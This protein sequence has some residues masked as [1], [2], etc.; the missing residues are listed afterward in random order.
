[1]I[2][3]FKASF[4]F[5]MRSLS[6]PLYDC[7]IHIF[8]KA[9]WPHLKW[10]NVMARFWYASNIFQ[11]FG[12]WQ[13]TYLARFFSL[14]LLKLLNLSFAQNT[15]SG[16]ENYKQL[17]DNECLSGNHFLCDFAK[18]VRVGL[19]PACTTQNNIVFGQAW[20]T[21]NVPLVHHITYLQPPLGIF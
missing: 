12:Q 3:S 17:T 10:V 1:M 9:K 19:S 8:L 16:F 15:L 7:R 13:A 4:L 21:L 11:T 18:S 20:I 5:P 6:F 2:A 14:C